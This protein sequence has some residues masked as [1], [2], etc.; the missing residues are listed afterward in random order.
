MGADAGS[1]QRT[2]GSSADNGGQAASDP[3]RS[4]RLKLAQFVLL[5]VCVLGVGGGRRVA[6]ASS[7]RPQRHLH[8]NV[9]SSSRGK[10]FDRSNCPPPQRQTSGLKPRDDFFSPPCLFCA[11][12][13]CF[14]S[15]PQAKVCLRCVQLQASACFLSPLSV[16]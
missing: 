3:T 10:S 6:T 5:S 9:M 2:A 11:A 12:L 4:R 15:H 1:S 13:F 14:V 16:K 8:E 7:P